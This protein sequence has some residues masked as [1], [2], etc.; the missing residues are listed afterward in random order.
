[1]NLDKKALKGVIDEIEASRARQRG[2]TEFQREALKKAVKNHQL[3]AKAIRI[4]LQRRAMG[5][6]KRDEQDYYV[7]SYE[8]ALGGKK[9][10][11]EALESGA[12]IREA[13]AVGGISTGAAG[14]LAKVVQ[15]SEIVDATTG[16]IIEDAAPQD[17]TPPSVA[18]AEGNSRPGESSPPAPDGGAGAGTHSVADQLRK[19]I[20]A[21]TDPGRLER[22]A[23]AR[24]S[25]GA[26]QSDR[27]ASAGDDPTRSED[28]KVISV[29]APPQDLEMPPIP[30]F[31]RR[32]AA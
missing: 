3:D 20:P 1:M 22:E 16:E 10:A 28:R 23:A 30:D 18:T 25:C 21:S 6:A 19:Q 14:N 2:E 24:E 13:A 32:S 15:K 4:V 17:E 29:S 8:L 12:T 7:H 27:Q 11:I 5:E 9:A 31:L 26:E